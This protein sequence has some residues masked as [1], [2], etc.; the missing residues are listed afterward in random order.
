MDSFRTVPTSHRHVVC[1][2]KVYINK[3]LINTYSERQDHPRSSYRHARLRRLSSA[4]VSLA[5]TFPHYLSKSLSA[6][7]ELLADPC[8]MSSYSSVF[9][10]WALDDRLGLGIY[11]CKQMGLVP[12]GTGDWLQFESRAPVNHLLLHV[13]S[14]SCAE[15]A[16]LIS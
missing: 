12:T 9:L 7:T 3:N 10:L 13:S 6:F 8:P 15:D 2:F 16:I 14:F 1:P 4:R 5:L 11:K